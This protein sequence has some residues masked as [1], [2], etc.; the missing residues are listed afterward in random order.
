MSSGIRLIVGLGNPGPEYANTRHNAGA[1][2]IDMLAAAEQCTL[3]RET[4]F[5]GLHGILRTR[6]E[7]L[8]I[9]SPTTFMNHS[10]QSVAA[11]ARFYQIPASHI[12]IVHDEIDL[13]VGDIRLKF[14]GGHGGHN[15]LRDIIRHLGTPQFHRLR[16]GV[17][18]PG[19]SHDV[20][21]Y[22]LKAP[23]KADFTIIQN[24]LRE[25]EKILPDLLAGKFQHAM[26]QLHT[27]E[28]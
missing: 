18:H 11:V 25:A 13:P 15:G 12:L 22:V 4:K 1:W 9:L 6:S 17:G 26:Q 28:S 27:K 16:I 5:H 23:S 21:D 8:H 20:V 19:N 2:F 24:N 14:D 10:G 7:D 3:K